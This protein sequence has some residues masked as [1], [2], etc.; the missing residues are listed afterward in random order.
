METCLYL[1]IVMVPALWRIFRQGRCR[2][3]YL[4]RAQPQLL[5]VLLNCLG[6]PGG[7]GIE[8]LAKQ[9]NDQLK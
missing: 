9:T 6:E 1:L 8:L 4:E 3:L 7:K 5:E 2:A